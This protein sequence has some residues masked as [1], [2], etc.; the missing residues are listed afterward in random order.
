MKLKRGKK[1]NGQALV[2]YVMVILMVAMAMGFLFQRMPQIFSI[3][4]ERITKDFKYTYKYGD[5]DARGFGDEDGPKRHPRYYRPNNF[6]LF[7]RGA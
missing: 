3:L 5:K 1:E 7:G 6:R 4:E 2:E